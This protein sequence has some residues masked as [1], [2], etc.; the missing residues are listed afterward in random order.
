MSNKAKRISIFHSCAPA[1]SKLLG[2][3]DALY[4]CPICGKGYSEESAV[5][6]ELTLED[7]PPLSTGGKGLLLTCKECNSSAGHRIDY[8]IKNQMDLKKL[9][10]IML[11]QSDGEKTSGDI[12]INGE[13][14]P[15]TVQRTA[16]CTEIRLVGKA[17]DPN[18]VNRLKDYMAVISASGKWDDLEFNINKTVK[19]DNRLLKIAFLKSGFLLITALL[20]YT[21]AFN[22]RL[23][24]VREQIL[25][26]ANDLLGANFW[27][28]P[29]KDQPFPKCRILLVSKPLP[30]FLVTYDSGAVILPNPSSPIDLYEIISQQWD[31]GKSV[32]FAGE[33]Y[34]WPEKAVM[35]LD[36][37][38]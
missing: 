34:K 13:R 20:G 2:V 19:L 37:H 28:E 5:S 12:L 17:N 32:D 4:L 26:P 31:K 33:I 9:V 36:N 1:T 38:S 3:K 16:K 24:V 11:G 35:T 23:V 22:K 8:H 27:V 7:V 30:L 10:S 14:F 6:G 21:Y 18:K 15:V 25:N 29:G